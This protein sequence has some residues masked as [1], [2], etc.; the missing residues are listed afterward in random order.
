[1]DSVDTGN[2]ERKGAASFMWLFALPL[3]WLRRRVG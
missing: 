3:L 2:Y 1:D